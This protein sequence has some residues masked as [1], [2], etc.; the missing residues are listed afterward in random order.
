MPT[1]LLNGLNACAGHNPELFYPETEEGAAAAK[2]ICATCPQLIRSR[3]LEVALDQPHQFGVWGGQSAAERR[4]TLR[5][6]AGAAP[7]SSRPQ[8]STIGLRA[9]A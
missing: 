4:K 1:V 7:R 6:L 9:S 8:P 2:A 3:C 5:D